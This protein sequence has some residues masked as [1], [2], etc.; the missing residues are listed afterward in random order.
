MLTLALSIQ[1][2]LM[3]VYVGEEMILSDPTFFHVIV[4]VSSFNQ[5]TTQK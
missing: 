1:C 2:K 5:S 4:F 3:L